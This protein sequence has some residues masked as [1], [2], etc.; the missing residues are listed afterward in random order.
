LTCEFFV[1]NCTVDESHDLSREL[2]RSPSAR[3]EEINGERKG[4]QGGGGA[5]GPRS[6]VGGEVGMATT[7]MLS[8]I[9]SRPREGSRVQRKGKVGAVGA[10]QEISPNILPPNHF[11][12]QPPHF[13]YF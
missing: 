8:S 12:P 2:S 9:S 3:W 13:S 6:G 11:A 10:L 7:N 1:F 5:G 4:G